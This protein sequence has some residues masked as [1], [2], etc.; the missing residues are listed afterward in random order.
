MMMKHVC[1]FTGRNSGV[2]KWQYGLGYRI[3]YIVGY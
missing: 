3:Y 2:I 1:M